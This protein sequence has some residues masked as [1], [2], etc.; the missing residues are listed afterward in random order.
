MKKA[1]SAYDNKQIWGDNFFTGYL[2]CPVCESKGK[3]FEGVMM[4]S[5]DEEWVEETPFICPECKDE[6]GMPL[7]IGFAG[8]K[9]GKRE[10]FFNDLIKNLEEKNKPN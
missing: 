5:V 3:L 4:V 6:I 8:I 2:T 9:K 1:W 7:T 10:N